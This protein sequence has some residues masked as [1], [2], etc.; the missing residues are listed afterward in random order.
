MTTQLF[1]GYLS[2][3]GAAAVVA[4]FNIDHCFWL[5]ATKIFGPTLRGV[6][7]NTSFEIIGNAGVEGVVAALDDVNKPVHRPDPQPNW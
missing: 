4:V 3:A 2:P 6:L 1:N 7:F 5:A